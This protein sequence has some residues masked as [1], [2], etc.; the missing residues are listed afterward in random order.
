MISQDLEK[1]VALL[2]QGE[3][4]GMPTETVYGLAADATSVEAVAKIF[5]IKNRPTFDPLIVHLSGIEEVERVALD[6][7]PLAQKL[8]E[9]F[10]P[11]PL[12]LILPKRDLI[13]DLVSS[14]L[15]TIG[16]RVPRHPM[17]QSL[18]QKFG[19][20]L[21]A[22][23]AN[24]FGR[25]SPTSAEAVEKELGEAVKLILDG[26]PCEIGLESTIVGFDQGTPTI[27]RLGGISLEELESVLG[28]IRLENHPH[29]RPQAPGQIEQHYAPRKPLKLVNNLEELRSHREPSRGALIWG[30]EPVA[31][32]GEL[33]NLSPKKNWNEAAANFFQMLRALDDGPSL[34]L[35]ALRLPE[36]GLGRAINERLSRAAHGSVSGVVH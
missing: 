31:G 11:G 16:V 33:F 26:G 12:T 30:E 24:R 4:V 21:A 28:T 25:I 8:A 18:L 13:P 10:W 23:S 20:P 5:A 2:H 35:V 6:F 9:R 15:P 34:D 1:A 7:P 36:I 32:Y 14:G 27:L 29:A 22:P 3:C 19:K 17:A